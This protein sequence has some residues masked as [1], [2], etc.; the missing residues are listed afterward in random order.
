MGIQL[1][2]VWVQVTWIFKFTALGLFSQDHNTAYSF[3]A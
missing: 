3:Y 1:T 2:Y